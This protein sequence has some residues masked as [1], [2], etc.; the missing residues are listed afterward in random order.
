VHTIFETNR[1]LLRELTHDDLDDLA[2]VLGDPEA[3][4]HYPQVKSREESL[5]WIDWNI[6]L[7]K[8]VGYGLWAVIDKKT[9]ACLGDCGITPQK[10]GTEEKPE[11]GFHIRRAAWGQGYATEAASACRELARSKFELDHLVAII[12]PANVP[13]Q[14]VA[15][16][17]GMSFSRD[18]NKSNKRQRLY[19]INLRSLPDAVKKN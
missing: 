2:G 5:A 7:Y 17:M 13:S 10:V 1:L 4:T 3:M 8:T 18:I 14:R 19:A 11:I 16:K 6:E 12:D 15:Q 9:G